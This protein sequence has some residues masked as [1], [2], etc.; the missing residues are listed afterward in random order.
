MNENVVWQEQALVVICHEHLR[1]VAPAVW[2]FCL[3]FG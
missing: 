1:P 3:K 2:K